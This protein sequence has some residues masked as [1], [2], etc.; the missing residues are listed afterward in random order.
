[1]ICEE[2]EGERG[3][4]HHGDDDDFWSVRPGWGCSRLELIACLDS[5]ASAVF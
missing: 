3:P 2:G 1:M 5:A 4:C